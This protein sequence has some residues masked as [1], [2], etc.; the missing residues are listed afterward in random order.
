MPEHSLDQQRAAFAW[1]QISQDCSED[2]KNLAKSAPA[3]VMT[4]GLMQTLA[5]LHAKGGG[6]KSPHHAKLT[7]DLCGWLGERFGGR[8]VGA[9]QTFQSGAVT[10]ESCMGALAACETSFYLEATEEA[11]EYLKWVRQIADARSAGG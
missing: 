11:L 4:N 10:F 7:T 6:G 8:Q 2:Y 9:G 3:L 5:F 1:S